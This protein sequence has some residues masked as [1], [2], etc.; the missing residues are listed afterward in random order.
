MVLCVH[1][2]CCR[3]VGSHLCA[4]DLRPHSTVKVVDKNKHANC[5]KETIESVSSEV[6]AQLRSI[7]ETSI[8]FLPGS[9]RSNVNNQFFIGCS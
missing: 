4:Q 7:F 3:H 9:D 6:R 8:A 1:I 2:D 5:I